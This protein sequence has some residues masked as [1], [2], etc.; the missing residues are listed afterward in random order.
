MFQS[1]CAMKNAV[2]RGGVEGTYRRSQR[3]LYMCACH[4]MEYLKANQPKLNVCVLYNI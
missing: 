1:S 4:K 3:D 2:P